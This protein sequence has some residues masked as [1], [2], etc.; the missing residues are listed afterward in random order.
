MMNRSFYLKT[1]VLLGFGLVLSAIV[2]TSVIAYNSYEQLS[3]SVQVLSRQDTSLQQVD[4]ILVLVN[5][6]ENSLQ[7][8]TIDKSPDKLH[9]YDS[10][11]TDVR[12]RVQQLKATSYFDNT[13][14]D[15]ILDL[16][17]AKLISMDEFAAIRQQRDDFQFYDK[18]LMQ[19]EEVREKMIQDA[20]IAES[21]PAD[22]LSQEKPASPR[23]E[24]KDGNSLDDQEE[25]KGWLRNIYDRLFGNNDEKGMED[26]IDAAQPQRPEPRETNDSLPQAGS[27]VAAQ[28]IPNLTVDSVRQMLQN[29][30]SEQAATEAYLNRQELEYLANNALVMDRINQH[31]SSIKAER[32][33]EY[34]RQSQ[35][36]STTLKKALS[37]LGVILIIALGST[38]LF[39]YLIFSDIA[40]SDFL[41]QQLE[42]AKERAEKLARIKEEFLANMSHEIRTPLTAILGFTG[43]VKQTSLNPKQAEYIEAVDS[44][45]THLLSLVN[46]ILDFSKI[47]AGHLSFEQKSFDLVALIEQVSADMRLQAEK[48]GLQL[49][50]ETEGEAL[51]YVMGDAFRLRQVL[52]NLVTNAIKFTEEGGVIVRARLEHKDDSQ[53][54]A[55]IQIID[56]GIGI[57]PEKQKHIFEAFVQSDVSD[58]RK[59]GGTGL[60]LSISKKIIEAQGGSIWLESEPREGTTFHIELPLEKSQASEVKKNQVSD[61]QKCSFTGLKMLLID[62][63][64]LNTQLLTTLLQTWGVQ[65]YTAHT[66]QAGLEVLKS[67]K[68][69]LLLTDLQM[70]EMPGEE[71][72]AAVKEMGFE[73]PLIAFTA[74]VTEQKGYFEKKGFEGV[75]YKPFK[76]KDVLAILKEFAATFKANE[77]VCSSGESATS[78]YAD[79]YSEEKL[80]TFENI[81]RFIGE[82]QE[83]LIGYLES[84]LRG[85][86]DATQNIEKGLQQDNSSPVGYYAHRLYSNVCQ[87]EVPELPQLLRKLEHLSK[88]HPDT[89]GMKSEARE[90][91]GLCRHLEE[92]LS[93]ELESLKAQVS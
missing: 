24:E 64:P 5:R 19:L 17:N 46:D 16:I 15:S 69:H 28:E 8:Y 55:R 26:E 52:Y 1:K 80:Y 75:L 30:K 42:K 91:V 33:Q 84:F 85:L 34:A 25:D 48:K 21:K 88:E 62:D 70:P 56:S 29:L 71:V 32:Q 20:L 86:Q 18:A 60:G 49:I 41:K 89:Q 78:Q 7:E 36:A 12:Q 61:A 72:A 57:A 77:P 44:S 58:T 79:T 39:V 67:E 51:R 92:K 53:A 38:F 90:A 14:L 10:L 4:S 2:L 54:L 27:S 73:I 35:E 74:R 81:Q 50:T 65:C 9:D 68:V 66:G 63:E 76:E 6:S 3:R 87:L 31:V 93:T 13:A 82:D 23:Q 45:S 11:V 22:A 47:E 43:L 59:Y 83:S 37:R 40:K